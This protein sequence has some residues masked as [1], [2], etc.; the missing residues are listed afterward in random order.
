[1]DSA[2][3]KS[4]DWA[5]YSTKDDKHW[6]YYGLKKPVGPMTWQG[7]EEVSKKYPDL[8]VSYESSGNSAKIKHWLPGEIIITAREEI[9]NQGA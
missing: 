2:I 3:K 5:N 4:I 7:I 6:F 1:V 8:F 9:S